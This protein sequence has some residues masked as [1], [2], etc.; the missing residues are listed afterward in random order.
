MSLMSLLCLA[1]LGVYN[2]ALPFPPDRLKTTCRL[3]IGIGNGRVKEYI[4]HFVR[5]V[6]RVDI[7]TR[8]DQ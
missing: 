2:D 1:G 8:D 6:E 3:G 5:S 7:I 4:C